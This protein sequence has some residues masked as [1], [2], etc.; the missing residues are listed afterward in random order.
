MIEPGH[1][2]PRT[3]GRPSVWAAGG[4]VASSQPLAS[5]VGVDVLRRGGNAI[6]AAVAMSA[7]L[8][9]LE[10]LATGVGGDLLAMVRLGSSGALRVLNASGRAPRRFSAEELRARGHR[11]MPRRG[12]ETITV[13]GA[14][15]GWVEL[16][17]AHGTWSL[18]QALAPAIEHA[19]RG[20][21]VTEGIAA[22]WRAAVPWLREDPDSARTW[23]F[24]G[25]APEVGQRV[26]LP[27]LADTLRTLARGGR[28]ALYR[29]PLGE[30]I[31]RA[32]EA[33]GGWLGLDDL[34]EHR[35]EWTRPIG[36][37]YRDHVV[38][39]CPP[40]GQGALVLMILGM[41][42]R[43]ELRALPPAVAFHAILEATKLAFDVRDLRIGDITRAEVQALLEPDAVAR[44]LARLDLARARPEVAAPRLG[45]DTTA[46]VVVDRERN[47]VSLLAS[48]YEDF[49][50]GVTAGDTGIV[51][52][53][54]GACFTL[55]PGH[56]NCAAPGRRPRHTLLPAMV[57]RDRELVLALAVMG[58]ELQPQGQVQILH[59][60]IDRGLGLQAAIDH[61]RVGVRE[62]G[63]VAFDA[64][65]PAEV[66]E[67]LRAR[68]HRC[69]P[70]PEYL[71][72][73]QAIA[74]HDGG[75]RL[76]GG[77]DPRKDGVALGY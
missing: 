34:A 1:P 11:A 56:P 68:G 38:W 33:R 31:V 51:L 12:V 77:S 21:L 27:M 61:P 46:L 74:L 43:L 26:R 63:H 18:E 42:E 19:E 40:N 10:P 39:Q 15:D 48:L 64:A 4:M 8:T 65:L 2:R 70:E 55:E 67:G 37:T 14:V 44:L 29:G 17:A 57:T 3:L 24:G 35:S 36:A 6:D 72:G 62:G 32:V 16:L 23:L 5:L 25:R 75:A 58:A 22:E 59:H 20:Y 73:A 66:L 7:L 49:G 60:V 13:P 45:S 9:V 47:A 69:E 71:G 50:S 30:A 76:E 53:D 54:R 41:L 52:H 28:D